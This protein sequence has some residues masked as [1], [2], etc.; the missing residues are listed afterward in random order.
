MH[1]EPSQKAFWHLLAQQEQLQWF[2]WRLTK[3]LAPTPYER[4]MQLSICQMGSHDSWFPVKMSF[5]DFGQTWNKNWKDP[6]SLVSSWKAWGGLWYIHNYP[7]RQF[8][9]V[10][11]TAIMV[12]NLLGSVICIRILSDMNL[13][14]TPILLF[15]TQIWKC[16]MQWK[17]NKFWMVVLPILL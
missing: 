4:D 3:F 13:G 8:H 1:G 12:M 11:E 7:N 16:E 5:T 14:S 10:I 2:Q 15:E 17:L 9:T 6:N